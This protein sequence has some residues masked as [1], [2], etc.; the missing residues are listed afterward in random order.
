MLSERVNRLQVGN[1]LR[2]S[3]QGF[4]ELGDTPKIHWVPMADTLFM[5][6]WRHATQCYGY[7]LPKS[8]QYL[9]HVHDVPLSVGIES[10]YGLCC[11]Q[12]RNLESLS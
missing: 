7:R 9:T 4:D 5:Q 12:E 6:C 11:H 2:L 10:A 3:F 8:F 1:Q